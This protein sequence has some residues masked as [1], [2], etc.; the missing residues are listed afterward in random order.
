MPMESLSGWAV[1]R[2][3]FAK[4]IMERMIKIGNPKISKVEFQRKDLVI[5]FYFIQ[6][7]KIQFSR[8][9]KHFCFLIIERLRGAFVSKKHRKFVRK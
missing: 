3:D 1:N 4:K 5:L 6:K 8:C 9:E 7:M 2:A